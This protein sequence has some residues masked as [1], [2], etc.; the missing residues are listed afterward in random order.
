M[1][2]IRNGYNNNPYHNFRHAFDVTQAVYLFLT[3]GK[4]AELLSHIEILG[5]LIAALSHDLGH[6][7]VN[8]SFLINTES[9]LAQL[10]ND[11]SVL[12]NFH[13][14][15][16]WKILKKDESAILDGIDVAQRR[17]LR[18]IIISCILVTDPSKTLE[19]HAKFDSIMSMFNRD[20][21]EHRQILA[22]SLIKCAD[23]SNPVRSFKV[24]KYWAEM[25]QEEFYNQGD[26]EKELG[27]DVSPFMD[28]DCNEALPRIQVNFMEFLVQPLYTTLSEFLPETIVCKNSLLNN[29]QTWLNYLQQANE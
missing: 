13:A 7:G 17:E 25:I 27:L 18:R 19:I 1:V 21:K 8:N 23:I 26:K 15:Q 20:N 6:P 28:R 14:S 10:Y 16:L 5:L 12:E 4:A 24:S 3:K 11:I 22:Q 9:P 29:K 2:E